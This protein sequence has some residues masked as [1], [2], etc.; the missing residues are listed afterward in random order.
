MGDYCIV[1]V[2]G[3]A[4]SRMNSAPQSR[5]YSRIH[6]VLAASRLRSQTPIYRPGKPRDKEGTDREFEGAGVSSREEQDII[7]KAKR[8]NQM[9]EGVSV[10]IK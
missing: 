7:Q 6:G 4:R 10:T 5:Y 8:F 2:E 3:W 1:I 9:C